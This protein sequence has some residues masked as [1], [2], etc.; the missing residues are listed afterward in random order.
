[1]AIFIDGAQIRDRDNLSDPLPP[2]AVVDL[3]QSLS[4]G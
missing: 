3:V 4:G 1:M 2:D